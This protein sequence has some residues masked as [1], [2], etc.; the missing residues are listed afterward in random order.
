MNK[1]TTVFACITLFILLTFLLLAYA[2]LSGNAFSLRHGHAAGEALDYGAT[3]VAAMLSI[4]E[5][6]DVWERRDQL[7]RFL[8]GAPGLPTALPSEVITGYDDKRYADL[9]ALR[10]IDKVVIKLDFGLES[11][12][13]HFIPESPNNK[14]VLYHEG[15]RG[16]FHRSKRQIR[17]F[18]EHGYAVL[19]FSMPLLGLNNQPTI[20]LPRIGWLKLTLHDQIK[21]LVPE[22]GH[23]IKYFIEPVVVGLNYLAATFDYAFVAMVGISGGGWTTTLAAAADARITQS[24]PVAGTYPIY[25]R[26]NAP[27]D[28]GDYEQ[29]EPGLY[30]TVNYLELYLLGA[31]GINRKQL[32][33]INKYDSCC[34]AGTKWDTYKDTV[35]SRV[36][37]VGEGKFDVF[38][39]GSHRKHLI[40]T[41]AMRRILDEMGNAPRR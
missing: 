6:D 33:I 41:T 3:D 39:D 36:R 1:K 7:I 4:R 18:L 14:V 12:A 11:T 26:S 32:Q 29:T 9:R 8:W 21:F 31:S 40:S 37:Q 15:H 24:Y 16:D 5:P 27:R 38:L 17:Q 20:H 30:N 25:L 35:R 13:Y 2:M 28:W 10:R 22:H 34:F 19:A 23:P